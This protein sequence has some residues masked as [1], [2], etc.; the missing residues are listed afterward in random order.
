MKIIALETAADPGSVA[1]W[2]DGEVVARTCPADVSNSAGLL[3]L[4]ID[5][6]H[7][8]G[9]TFSDLDGVAFGSGPGSFTGLRVAC[10]VAQGLAVS[11]SLPLIGVNTLEAMA[12]SS[13]GSR[14]LVALDARMGEVY[15]GVF[16]AGRQIGDLG[17][18]SP[19][20]VPLPPGQ[21]WLACGNGLGAYPELRER[22]SPC[23]EVW[24]P[25][26]MPCAQSVARL[27][28]Q[29]LS[30]GEVFDLERALPVYVRDKVAKTVAERLAEG[31]RA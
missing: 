30:N 21:G 18:Y 19:A 25:E 27:A 6:L 14:V 12:L 26:I 1:L 7:S 13:G 20:S 29:R 17:V 24:L 16:E 2:L 4:A 9:L 28:A 5:L 8:R 22:L 15:L 3:P 11:R 31:G 10:G 23:V